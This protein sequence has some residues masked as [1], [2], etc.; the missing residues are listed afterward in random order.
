MALI[1]NIII[2]FFIFFLY[3]YLEGGVEL[4]KAVIGELRGVLLE[5][6][7]YD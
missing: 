2:L 6:L 7:V 1:V 4:G 5:P 3:S